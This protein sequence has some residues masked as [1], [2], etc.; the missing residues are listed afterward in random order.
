MAKV[1]NI[2]EA[3]TIALHSVILIA[4]NNS[5]QVNVNFIAKATGSSKFHIAKVLQKLVKDDLLGSTRGPAGGFY[6]IDKP[7]NITLLEVYESIE[8]K[9]VVSRCPLGKDSCPFGKC[10]FEDLTMDMTKNFKDYLESRTVGSY[11][12]DKNY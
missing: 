1:V 7:E 4:K 2:T 12:K 5:K 8:G 10:V 6:L 9:I 3:V 11:M